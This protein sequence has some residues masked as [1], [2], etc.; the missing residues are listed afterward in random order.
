ME[1]IIFDGSEGAKDSDYITWMKLNPSAFVG[2][3]RRGVRSA[4]SCIHNAG[5]LHISSYSRSNREDSFTTGPYLKVCSSSF[6]SL[7]EWI[8]TNR[9]RAKVPRICKTCSPCAGEAID[10]NTKESRLH[11]IQDDGKVLDLFDPETTNQAVVEQTMRAITERR[12]Q[13]EF[14]N[15]LLALYNCRCAMSNCGVLEVLEAAHIFP[16][17]GEQ[18][19]ISCNGII[20]RADLHTL[21]DLGMITI[22]EEFKIV[23][24]NSLRESSYFDFNGR[25][26]NLPISSEAKPSMRAIRWHRVHARAKA[27]GREVGS[28]I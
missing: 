16:Y 22:D 19:N 25:V 1:L 7:I 4:Y 8:E 21:F 27:T 5:C 24:D 12:G 9:P 10:V 2:N 28:D 14:R 13:S 18:T 26:L 20:L 17:K 11:Y 23:V 3:F 6:A 15:R